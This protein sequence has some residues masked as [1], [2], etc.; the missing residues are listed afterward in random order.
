MT[1]ADGPAVEFRLCERGQGGADRCLPIEKQHTALHRNNRVYEIGVAGVRVLRLELAT[2]DGHSA[3]FSDS[4]DCIGDHNW[5]IVDRDDGNVEGEWGSGAHS[6]RHCECEPRRRTLAP[7]MLE[8]D[9]TCR[10]LSLGERAAKERLARDKQA[11][12]I[13]VSHGVLHVIIRGIGVLGAEESACQQQVATLIDCGTSIHGHNWRIIHRIHTD[14][15]RLG[16]SE[17]LSVRYNESKAGRG[18]LA[19]VVEEAY[20][21][22]V[23]VGL[24]ES[25]IRQGLS[26]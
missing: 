8:A 17:G 19:A 25:A 22:Y 20:V 11:A 3:T 9:Q 14:D 6:I 16:R 23:K 21:V 4:Q 2:T 26:F 13:E 24:R 12:T 15:E 7:V 1:E 18:T 10:E 5:G